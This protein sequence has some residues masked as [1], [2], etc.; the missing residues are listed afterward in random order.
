MKAIKIIIVMLFLFISI[1]QAEGGKMRLAILDLQP[2]S[3]SPNTASMVSDLLRTELFNTGLFIVIERSE[4]QTI[5]K[6]QE[7]QAGGCTDTECAVQIGRLLSANKMLVGT[8]GKLGEKYIINARIVDVEKGV[9]EFAD[10]AKANSE[11]DLDTAVKEFAGKLANKISGKTGMV[12]YAELKKESHPA[13]DKSR[14][15]ITTFID[16]FGGLGWTKLDLKFSRYDPPLSKGEMDVY[17]SFSDT[18]TSI[19]WEG[20]DTGR[21]MPL[22]FRMGYFFYNFG[23][24]FDFFYSG[25]INVAKQITDYSINEIKGDN[26][27]FQVDDY[28]KV[29]VYTFLMELLGRLPVSKALDIYGGGVFGISANTWNSPYIYGYTHTTSSFS[30]PS[31]ETK[32]GLVFG[33]VAGLRWYF[34]NTFSL[35]GEGRWQKNSF[36]FTRNIDK[37]KDEA[38]LT[39]ISLLI[40]T[41]ISW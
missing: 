30:R 33:A 38:R 26:F 39:T 8:L 31:E 17:G 32:S 34:T 11:G 6:E 13:A 24:A 2:K 9:M 35:L 41:G 36:E 3:V 20:L 28:F 1:I 7:F 27:S 5:L 10:N 22:G 18:F 37:E 14:P 21:K 4:M 23:F 19:S 25:S 12:P 16:V 29:E 40:G 15:S